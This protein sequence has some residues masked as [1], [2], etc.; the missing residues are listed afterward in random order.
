MI[1]ILPTPGYTDQ[2]VAPPEL[3]SESPEIHALLAKLQ[4]VASAAGGNLEPSNWGGEDPAYVQTKPLARE[5]GN[6]EPNWHHRP[7]AVE[8]GGGGGAGLGKERCVLEDFTPCSTSH[9]WKLMM[10]FYDRKGV[11]SWSQVGK[12]KRKRTA[13]SNG[14]RMCSM[15]G[16]SAGCLSST[17]VDR[18]R[19]CLE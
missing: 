17:R 6:G 15:P 19:P 12:R 3:P 9:L 11:E 5:G 7:G 4:D 2:F 8:N 1:V 10:S 13:S 16:L 14:F 18:D